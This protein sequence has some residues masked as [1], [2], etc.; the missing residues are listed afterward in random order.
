VFYWSSKRDKALQTCK[1]KYYY[2]C[3]GYENGWFEDAPEENQKAWRLKKLKS[4]PQ[5]VGELVG[6][7]IK[8]YLVELKRGN[9]IQL[10]VLLERLEKTFDRDFEQSKKLLFKENPKAYIGLREHEYS[11]L[12]DD[13]FVKE[14]LELGKQCITN[15]LES[16]ILKEIK[17]APVETWIFPGKYDQDG[18]PTF[19]FENTKVFSVFK[20][21]ILNKGALV[22][23]DWTTGSEKE[24]E[25]D[26]DVK[27]SV[28]LIFFSKK[29][30]LLPNQIKVKKIY[31][32]D[33]SVELVEF[34]NSDAARIKNHLK[35][36]ISE[37]K[38]LLDDKEKNKATKENFEKTNNES[39][40]TYCNYKKIC[41]PLSISEFTG[42]GD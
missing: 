23:Y 20:F 42:Y 21:G 12:L 39:N 6:N 40:C 35:G 26:L 17:L 9:E 36:S 33:N 10:R 11:L 28:F 24:L 31:L 13:S 27:H 30:G 41:S 1:R 15:F 29:E 8:E 16:D 18:F 2:D 5:R 25:S 14:R 7:L 32:K 19:Y 22:L 34:T 4:I 37:M 3:Y 38:S